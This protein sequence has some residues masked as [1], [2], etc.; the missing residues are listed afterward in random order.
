M[1]EMAASVVPECERTEFIHSGAL[2]LN[3]AASCRGL[4]GGWGRGRIH[5]V[6]GDGSSGKTLTQLELLAYA[7]HRLLQVKTEIFPKPKRLRLVYYNAENVMDF[8]VE[9]MYSQEFYDAVE[10]KHKP[11]VEDMGEHFF[12]E[13]V[14]NHREGDV[15]IVVVDSWDSIRSKIDAQN[16]EKNLK[17]AA[18]ASEKG[19]EEDKAKGSFNLGKQKYG[20]QYF[21]PRCCAEMQGKDITLGIISQVRQKIGVTFGEKRYRAGGDALNFY[22][23]QVCW[24][25]EKQKL[26]HTVDGHTLAYGIKVRGRFKRNKCALPFREAEFD[27]ILNYGI[28]DIGSML[29]WRYGPKATEIKWRGKT[30]KRK[31]LAQMLK[32][33]DMYAIMAQEITEQW[34]ELETRANPRHGQSKYGD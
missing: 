23:H 1:A 22:T 6:V 30:W 9:Q 21:F 31:E 20:S 13:V 28:E 19:D 2:M 10:W 34:Q 7:Y 16:Y 26:T 14:S 27:I 4:G 11:F 33:P 5:N 25:A 32:V 12:N 29:D 15:V 18:K 8:P 24:L 17:K 3:L